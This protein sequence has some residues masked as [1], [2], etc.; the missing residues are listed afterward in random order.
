[1]TESTWTFLHRDG[2][3]DDRYRPTFRRFL[4]CN[5]VAS[6]SHGADGEGIGRNRLILRIRNR[7]CLVDESGRYTDPAEAGIAPGDRI[8]AGNE[9]D[10]ASIRH[11]RIT[12]VTRSAGGIGC[13]GGW[14]ITAE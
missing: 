9:T 5:A 13:S 12:S 14:T 6:G 11:W 4:C 2:G 10:P 8:T 7:A 1:M 3:Y